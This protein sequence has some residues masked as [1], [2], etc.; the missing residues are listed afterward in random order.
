M[1]WIIQMITTPVITSQQWLDQTKQ[2]IFTY[3]INATL[4]DVYVEHWTQDGDVAWFVFFR[5]RFEACYVDSR[6][7]I[8]QNSTWILMD[9]WQGWIPDL[10]VL[11]LVNS[12]LWR[13]WFQTQHTLASTLNPPLNSSK[14]SEQAQLRKIVQTDCQT[15]FETAL[16]H[17]ETDLNTQISSTIKT[18]LQQKE[19][20]LKKKLGLFKQPMP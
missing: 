20:Q 3:P 14:V 17:F 11:P 15:H 2:S 10:A 4:S 12:K 8:H 7:Y 18:R 19:K 1:N 9:T 6:F 16:K 5:S 13:T